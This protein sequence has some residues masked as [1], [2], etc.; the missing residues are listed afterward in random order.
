MR[1]EV[2]GSPSADT[3]SCGTSSNPRDIPRRC[4]VEMSPVAPAPNRKS[5][6][7]CTDTGRI[8]ESITVSTNDS[9]AISASNGVNGTTRMTSM[10]VSAMQAS[11]SARVSSCGAALPGET[12]WSGSRSKVTA[13]A[14]TSRARAS[15]TASRKQRLMPDVD[16]VKD[17]DGDG[18]SAEVRGVL[19][20]CD[21]AC[22][23]GRC[24]VSWISR[25]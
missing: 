19:R 2:T 1:V 7:T 16:A 6:P 12:T 22:G 17:A 3:R 23:Q 18:G 14:R 21:D 13:T 11:L 8:A 9:G 15:A 5:R 25:T 24:S 4:R 20:P 10:P